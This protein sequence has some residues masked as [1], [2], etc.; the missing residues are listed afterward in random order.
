MICPVLG[1]VMVDRLSWSFAHGCNP[2]VVF[3]LWWYRLGLFWYSA[4]YFLFPY[5][6]HQLLVG[7]A[8]DVGDGPV[9]ECRDILDCWG[10]VKFE[11]FGVQYR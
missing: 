1:S 7:F 5:R 9:A 8:K 6:V 11:D 10:F 3:R 4:S 2:V